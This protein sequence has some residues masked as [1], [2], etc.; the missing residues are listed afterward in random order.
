[1]SARRDRNLTRGPP[2]PVIPVAPRMIL[3]RQWQTGAWIDPDLR[4]GAMCFVL[5]IAAY[6]LQVGPI[7]LATAFG[8]RLA[9]VHLGRQR[10]PS[11]WPGTL[12]ARLIGELMGAQLAPA[13]IGALGPAVTPWSLQG[14]RLPGHISAPWRRGARDTLCTPRSARSAPRSAR[15]APRSAGYAWRAR[16]SR[17][18]R[19]RATAALPRRT[20]AISRGRSSASRAGSQQ[21]IAL[22]DRQLN[23]RLVEFGLGLAQELVYIIGHHERCRRSLPGGPGGPFNVFSQSL[24]L[25]LKPASTATS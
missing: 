15:C 1:M 13:A 3:P 22:L 23:D 19:R 21:P 9:V 25:P 16:A 20:A 5:A 6:A 4:S 10:D 24:S 12:A 8:Y 17:P 7:V 2:P 18:W 14:G 11:A